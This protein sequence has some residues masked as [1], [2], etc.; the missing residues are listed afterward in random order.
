MA[1][2]SFSPSAPLNPGIPCRSIAEI[3]FS[4]APLRTI[5]IFQTGPAHG[6]PIVMYIVEHVADA[7]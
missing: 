1:R 5:E 4:G 6:V 2:L 3:L 7:A